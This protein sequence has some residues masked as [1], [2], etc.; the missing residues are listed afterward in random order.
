MQPDRLA[1]MVQFRA[2]PRMFAAVQAEARSAGLTVS[3]Y[4]RLTIKQKLRQC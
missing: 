3:E 2:D 4:L 1:H